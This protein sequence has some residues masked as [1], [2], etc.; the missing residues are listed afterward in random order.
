MIDKTLRLVASDDVVARDVGGEAVLLNLASGTYFGL[1]QV[2]SEVWKLLD[3]GNMT[4]VDLCDNIEQEF[5][6]P[7]SAIERDVAA[8]VE[9]L[10]THELVTTGG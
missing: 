7:R 5:D 10:I 2:G 6:A 3:G 1:N 4:L 8:L 9:E